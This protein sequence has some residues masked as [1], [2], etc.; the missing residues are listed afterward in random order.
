MPGAEKLPGRNAAQLPAWLYLSEESF[1]TPANQA[2]N[3]PSTASAIVIG[4][5]TGAVYY[6]INGA[7]AG[8]A[9]GGY[10]PSG[11]VQ[12]IGPV[13]NLVSVRITSAD[14]TAHITY[15]REA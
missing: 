2:L 13:A 15:W 1:A 5:E 9:S 14:G 11:Q 6:S 4:A 12:A 8:A 10:V 7:I 3:I